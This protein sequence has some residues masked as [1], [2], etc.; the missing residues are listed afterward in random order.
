MTVESVRAY[1]RE[2]GL[3][4][5]IHAFGE[6]TETVELA[7]QALGVEPELIAK[8]LAFKVRDRGVLVVTRGDARIDNRKFK[9]QFGVKAKMISPEE[10][11]DK[12]G[13]PVGGVCPFAIKEDMEIYPAA[14]S[15][16]SCV[17]IT[18]EELCRITGAQWADVCK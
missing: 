13:H 16:N 10:V 4:Y 15:K 6:S 14:G 3:G 9:D 2:N 5:E 1:F 18:P 7:A 11:L 17:E 8:T 12:T